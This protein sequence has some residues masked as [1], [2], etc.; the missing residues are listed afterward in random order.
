MRKIGLTGGIGSGKSTVARIFESMG[1]PVF[2][3]DA[4]GRAV[5]NLPEVQVDLMRLFGS[6]VLQENL[7]QRGYIA[8]RV[9]GDEKLLAEL[10]S[11]VHPRVAQAFDQWLA[12]QNAPYVLKEAAIIFE[13]GSDSSLDDVI[14]VC[15]SKELRIDRV[16]KRDAISREQVEARMRNQWPEDRKRSLASYEI[17]NDGV[18][19]LIPQLVKLHESLKVTL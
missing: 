14:L 6:D 13:T 17:V 4:V 15:A 2:Y 10:N 7:I 9:F 19:P 18:M 3:A 5:L 8:K 16:K 11:I 12:E 1:V